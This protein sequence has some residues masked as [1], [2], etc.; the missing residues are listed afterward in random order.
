MG[1]SV[2]EKAKSGDVE[3]QC[4][5]A[6]LFEIGLDREIDLEQALYWWQQAAAQGNE[7][8]IEKVTLVIGA[9]PLLQ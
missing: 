1:E 2:E 3:A 9:P 7:L 5:L 6:F 8:A 4:N